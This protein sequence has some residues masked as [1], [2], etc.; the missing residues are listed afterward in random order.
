MNFTHFYYE[1]LKDFIFSEYLDPQDHFGTNGPRIH[2]VL[3]EKNIDP[4]KWL[5]QIDSYCMV[6]SVIH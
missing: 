2:P 6:F 4:R 1:F 5:Y 3:A